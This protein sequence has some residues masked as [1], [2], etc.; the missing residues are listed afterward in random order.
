M[1][2]ESVTDCGFYPAQ[3]DRPAEDVLHGRDAA[4]ASPQGTMCLKYSRF[5]FTLSA[6]PC[7]VMPRETRT[8]IAAIL[9]SPNQTPWLRGD[10]SPP[11]PSRARASIITDSRVRTYQ[12]GPCPRRAQVQDRVADELA[13]TVERDIAAPIGAV[14]FGAACCQRCF[15][16]QQVRLVAACAQRVGRRV[17]QEDQRFVATGPHPLSDA[18][19]EP[20]GVLV[21]EQS[22]P[23]ECAAGCQRPVLPTACCLLT[24]RTIGALSAMLTALH[25]GESM[26]LPVAGL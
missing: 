1:I 15:A 10:R 9:A 16:H 5:V 23:E 17:F 19:L 11:I 26:L 3:I 6:K 4:S 24:E 12:D 8:P 14:N 22:G 13:R 2:G 20:P 21:G 7:V 18:L 25:A